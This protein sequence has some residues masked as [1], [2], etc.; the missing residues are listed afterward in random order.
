MIVRIRIAFRRRREAFARFHSPV[1]APARTAILMPG[2]RQNARV[3]VFPEGA[4]DAVARFQPEVLAASAPE[5]RRIARLVR[6]G[7]LSLPSLDVGLVALT[8]A[9]ERPLEQAGRDLLWSAFEL[10][11]YEQLLGPRHET[12]A[13]E[14]GAHAGL[15]LL[16]DAP[17]EVKVLRGE[18]RARMP[19]GALLDFGLRAR[20]EPGR[21]PCGSEAPRLTDLSAPRA[22]V[23]AVA[24]AGY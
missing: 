24:A 18:V 16:P 22:A 20:L 19:G 23:R 3:R 17:L 5:L 10:P 12:L 21:C 15:H 2:F 13:A 9:G 1:E 6:A 7:R 8:R 4:Y 11:V 14:C